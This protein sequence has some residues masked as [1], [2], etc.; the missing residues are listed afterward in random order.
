M[1]TTLLRT[2]CGLAC[3]VAFGA[4]MAASGVAL[5]GG[6]RCAA[7][8]AC[9]PESGA[10]RAR[11]Q[12]A[13]LLDTSGSMQGL[14]DQARTQIW[15]VVNSL[16]TAKQ[17][18]ERPRLEVALYEY[19]KSSIPAGEGHLR[20]ILALTDDLDE[21]SAQLF[22][23]TTNGGDE[24]CGRAID[25]ATRGL[26]WTT[27]K[28]DLRIILIAGNEPFTQG[29]V[30]YKAAVPEAVKRGIIVNTIHCGEREEGART[31][32][33]DGAT[34]G[35]GQYACIET[36]ATIAH[37]P[38]PFDAEITRLGT[39]LNTTYIAYGAEGRAGA[40]KQVM[41]DCAASTASPAAS[42]ERC[43]AKASG[44]YAN[45]RWDLVDS[46][47]DGTVKLDEVKEAE[48]PE[49]MRTMTTEQRREHVDG[50]AKK[51]TEIQGRLQELARQRDVFVAQE[52]TKAAGNGQDTTLLSA[53][54]GAIRAQATGRGFAFDA[55]TGSD[56][57]LQPRE[58]ASPSSESSPT[59][60]S[61]RGAEPAKAAE[62]C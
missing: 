15:S 12:L 16:A 39:E 23:L 27:S 42:V 48:L 34:L 37:V 41:Q 51:R 36:N 21:V 56:R 61:P 55:G 45:G 1:R 20:Q 30:D 5:A 44:L 9:P 3:G 31:G 59:K 40:A 14:I 50:Q 13:I 35:E 33:Q 18:G 38:S 58:G 28:D 54:L 10:S 7:L 19:G 52:R 46:L 29:E 26:A 32:W 47:K 4:V 62:G 60:A 6:E 17:G 11:V 25:A 24:F 22:A 2:A 8:A 43:V 57:V 53:M 49:A